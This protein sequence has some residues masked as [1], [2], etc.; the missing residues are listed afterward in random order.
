VEGMV[1]DWPSVL[2]RQ[3]SGAEID[4]SWMILQIPV[5]LVNEFLNRGGRSIPERKK[6]DVRQIFPGHEHSRAD[7]I[8]RNAVTE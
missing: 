3:G 7:S 8:E 5:A 2:G 6:N 4:H 1:I